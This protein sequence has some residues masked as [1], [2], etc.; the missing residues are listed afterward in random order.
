VIPGIR[1]PQQVLDNTTGLVK[2]DE[3]DRQMI[4]SLG[5][6]SFESLMKLIQQQG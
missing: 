3:M 1:T 5:K 6:T 4:E 2:L